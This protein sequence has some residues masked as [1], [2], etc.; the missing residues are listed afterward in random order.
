MH[1]LNSKLDIQFQEDIKKYEAILKT[2]SIYCSLYYSFNLVRARLK[3][4]DVLEL[5]YK[6]L[7]EH[8]S[9]NDGT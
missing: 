3:D 1:N 2:E 7:A 5:C 4:K 8:A 9:N 6:T